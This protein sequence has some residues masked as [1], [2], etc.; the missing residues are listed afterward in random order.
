V[1]LASSELP[2]PL[3]ERWGLGERGHDRGGENEV[4][5]YFRA[6]PAL[7]PVCWGGKLHVVRWGNKERLERKLPPTGWT[8]EETVGSGSWSALAP[9]EVEIPATYGLAGGVW[10]RVRRGMKGL[11]VK[12]RQ[13][14]P[15]VFMLTR[16]ST[17][18]FQVM[19]RTDWMPVLIDEVI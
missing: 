2:L 18:Y 7:L 8:W 1:A 12:D 9:E 16:P 13:G 19:T 15:V 5:F 11:L 17:R 6:S 4:R 10:F 14:D 3:V